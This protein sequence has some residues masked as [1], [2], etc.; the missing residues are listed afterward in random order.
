MLAEISG[1]ER[2]GAAL[3]AVSVRS[4]ARVAPILPRAPKLGLDRR[5]QSAR[6]TYL[7]PGAALLEFVKTLGAASPALSTLERKF[8]LVLVSPK[9]TPAP[10]P[11]G[12]R[13]V[14]W[15]V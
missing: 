3:L 2:A 8:G 12:Q 6:V 9:E 11:E 1:G 5:P 13:H 15:G 10:A 7:E 14:A 4:T